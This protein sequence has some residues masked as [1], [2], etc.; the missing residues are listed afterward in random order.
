M[1]PLPALLLLLTLTLDQAVT[2]CTHHVQRVSPQFNLYVDDD[3]WHI[4][5]YANR[6]TLALFRQCMHD[7]G[8]DGDISNLYMKTPS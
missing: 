8:Q 4:E 5:F 3:T 7:H 6:K 2:V 1:K